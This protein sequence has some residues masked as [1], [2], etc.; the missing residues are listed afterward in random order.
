[1][2]LLLVL[3]ACSSQPDTVE[4]T[5]ASTDSSTTSVT[6][7][8][9]T[10]TTLGGSTSSEGAPDLILHNGRIL[11]VDDDFTIADAVAV[12]DGVVSAVG[13]VEILDTAGSETNVVDLGGLTVMP[14]FIDPHTHRTQ[15]IASDLDAMRAGY[16]FMLE[17]GTT[18]NGV[19]H[20][21]PDE[22]EAFRTL[23][24]AGEIPLRTQMYVVYNDF[25]GG[26]DLGDFY[27]Q[28][29][30]SQDP[31]LRLTVAGVKIFTDGGACGASA[32]SLEY[33]DTTPDRLKDAGWVDNGDL[34][35]GA[36][37]V[38]AVVSEVDAAGGVTVI[39]AIGDLGIRVGLEGLTIANNEQPFVMHQRID[40]NSLSSLLTPEELSLY[41]EL[42]MT[43]VVF[44]VPWP[45]G[46]DPAVGETWQSIMPE[47]AFSVLENSEA[48]RA[49]NP[50]M[51]VSWHGDA[52]SV[53]GQP[54]QLMFSLVTGGAVDVDTG[55]PCYPELW[56]GF[57]T[58]DTE[59]ALRMMTIN[60]AAAMGIEEWVGSVEVGKI[61]D[62]LILTEDPFE[63][64]PEVGIAANYPLVTLIDGDVAHCIDLC[65]LFET[66]AGS[67]DPEPLPGGWEAVDH[68]LVVGVRAS[69]SIQ[70]PS[71][72]LDGSDETGWVSG[73]FAE[74][75]IEFDLGSPRFISSL[76]LMVDQDPAGFTVH[77]VRAG[78]HDNPGRLAASLEGETA[79]GDWLEAA[80]GYEV[81]FIRIKTTQ[82]P[83]WVAWLEIEI[84]E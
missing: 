21:G 72:V 23:E 65:E 10:I 59:E 6:Q 47:P 76:R 9:S 27:L 81:E 33:L 62:L 14:G 63:A 2:A 8:G 39:H 77:E 3:A 53:P 73:S 69:E 11:T 28:N 30:F 82:S 26:R 48:M 61:A 36:D 54:F 5:Q 43:P 52:P 13:S 84:N 20:V 56:E 49:A 15:Y 17:S 74:Q 4:T 22:L 38:A 55:E 80:V 75:W 31:S 24:A 66:T 58:V 41:G 46:C 83:S 78:A 57:Y 64:N 35:I 29:E 70:P 51:R 67:E 12:K 32:I 40:H 79:R 16:A 60:A 37:E 18:T 25:C 50:G 42:G 1:M 44:P 7:P 68:P 34:Y 45:G 71:Y 19:P